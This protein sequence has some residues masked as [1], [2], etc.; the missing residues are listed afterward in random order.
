VNRDRKA[1]EPRSRLY[2]VHLSID[3]ANEF[4]GRYHR[5]NKP[6]PGSVIN[7]GVADET[8]L[9]RGVAVIGRPVARKLDNGWT[10]EVNRVATDGCF[11]ACSALYAASRR[12]VFELGYRRLITY[13]LQEE[14]G[15]SMRAVGWKKVAATKP[16]GL[17]WHNRPGRVKQQVNSLP[18]Y[19]W[20]ATPPKKQPFEMVTYPWDM[21]RRDA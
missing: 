15:I 5:H 1:R 13:T 19:R 16:S 21:L 10:L 12:I 18:K 3:V 17:G 14:S 9:L 20:E 6:V 2:I 8:G 11:N 7:L 4:I